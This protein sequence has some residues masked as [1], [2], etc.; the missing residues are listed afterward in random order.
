MKRIV[1][2]AIAAMIMTACGNKTAQGGDQD[3]TATVETAGA[4]GRDG[5]GVPSLK[6]DTM[7]YEIVDGIYT[8]SYFVDYPV[9]GSDSL[10][11]SIRKFIND[12][13][14]GAYEGPLDKGRDMLKKDAEIE[15]GNFLESCGNADDEEIDELFLKKMVNKRVETDDFVTYRAFTSQYFGGAHGIAYESG[16]TFSKA[17]GKCFGYD[18]MKGLDSPAFK[19]LIK[20]G[21]RKFFSK[22]GDGQGMSDEDLKEE[23]V[24][25]DGSIDELPLP[26]T[27]PYM[28]EQGVTF[29]YQPYEI[30]YYAAGRPEFTVSFNDVRPYL[31]PQAIELFLS[32][33]DFDVKQLVM[34]LKHYEDYELLDGI[35]LKLIYEDSYQ[36]EEMEESEV[37]FGK[38]IE[39]GSKEHPIG[40]ALKATSDHAFYYSMA[41]DTSTRPNLGFVNQKDALSFIENT[42]KTEPFDYEGMTYYIHPKERDGER[43]IHIE[44]PYGGDDFETRYV[45]Y[46]VKQDN[47]FWRIEIEYYV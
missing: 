20:E 34:A 22:E 3:S 14:G 11:K 1:M 29:V 35:G 8:L 2:L 17:N 45:L 37:M 26:D 7:S 9:A 18:M 28:T 39:K 46:P 27:E 47:G 33:Q 4:E 10:V 16:H 43:Y 36:N 41:L 25:F 23:L 12:Y 31:K 21:L 6:T 13:L 44:T 40:F 32:R 24:S 42:L 15:F 19:R 5:V 30:S 38:D